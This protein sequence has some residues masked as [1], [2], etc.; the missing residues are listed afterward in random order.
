MTAIITKYDER[1]ILCTI[2]CMKTETTGRKALSHERIV[3]AAARAMR[4]DGFDGVGV[5]DVMK[6]AGLT[7]GGFYAHFE[8]RDE[9]LAEAVEHA[10][11]DIGVLIDKQVEQLEKLGMSAFR[12]HIEIYLSEGHALDCENGCPTS[13]LCAE[14]SRQAPLV[15]A[16]SREMI[17]RL[18]RLIA[19]R[20][21]V[22]SSEAAAWAVTSALVGAV[23]LARALGDSEQ[24]REVLTQTKNELLAR[25]DV[26]AL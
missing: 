5:A 12:A 2:T 4:R 7:H 10:A 9:L 6:S 16:A 17:G 19:G 3:R 1:H 20:L 26:P 14:V 24:A 25:Y 21:P 11:H 15:V 23:Q 18:H 13:A 22:G 8:S